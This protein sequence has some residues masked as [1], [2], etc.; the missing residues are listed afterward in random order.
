MAIT[1]V[2]VYKHRRNIKAL[3]RF[4]NTNEEMIKLKGQFK[5]WRQVLGAKIAGN[6][7][8]V[9]LQEENLAQDNV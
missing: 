4:I 8:Q 5:T 6:H 3:I 1:G 9:Q 2:A 7:H